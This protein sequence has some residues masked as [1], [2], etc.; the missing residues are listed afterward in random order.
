MPD[1]TSCFGASDPRYVNAI[2][3]D[4]GSLTIGPAP[5][6]ITAANS[7]ARYAGRIPQLGWS[8]NFVNNNTPAS[9][10]AQ[11]VCTSTVTLNKVGEIFSP[12]GEYPITCKGAQDQNYTIGY[13]A[14]RLTVDLA[15]VSLEY[16]G[17]LTLK[18][19]K[20]ATLGALI[21]GPNSG[22]V[23]DRKLSI[24]LGT[25]SSAQQCETGPSSSL[26]YAEC[27]IPR[28]AQPE[29]PDQVLI[30]FAGDSPGRYYDYASAFIKTSVTVD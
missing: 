16:Q 29:R 25:G 8:A 20:P 2:F 24:V 15:N 23:P 21:R 4:K 14:G 18:Y 28:V 9:L 17:P 22:P 27:T 13:A 12:A 26:G 6:T 11:P 7:S 1:V 10:T 30:S 5:L 19:G 3:Y